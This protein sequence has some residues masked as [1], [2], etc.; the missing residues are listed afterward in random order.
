M[1]LA[2]VS[3]A[4][5]GAAEAADLP[6]QAAP[7]QV[8]ASKVVP[9]W[10]FS[11]SG[12]AWA[13]SVKGRA[14][15][16]PPLPAVNVDVKFADI[17][18]NL[19]GAL[20]GTFEARN[21]PLMVMTDV[22]VSRVSPEHSFSVIG[23][24]GKLTYESTSFAGLGVVGYRLFETANASVDAFGGGRVWSMRNTLGL[25]V[26]GFAKVDR[27]NGETWVDGVVGGRLK[28]NLTDNLFFSVIGAIGGL[29]AKVEWDV[30]AGLNYRFAD[31][32]SAFLGYR[33]LHVDYR[34]GNF[35]YKAT[36]QGPVLGVSYRF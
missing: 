16:L 3:V 31:Q 7:P 20:M 29:S 5:R 4:S 35:L 22:V 23:I 1:V 26:P 17:L 8:A 30:Y 10:T 33:A 14:R 15:T 18:K 2:S 27:S 25:T 19:D 6:A 13:S 11:M 36:Q 34:R 21:G 12:Y 9:D 32:W 24:N 28:V